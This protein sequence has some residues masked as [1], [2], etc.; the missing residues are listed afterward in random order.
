MSLC[1]DDNINNTLIGT[2]SRL[3]QCDPYKLGDH[4]YQ[5]YNREKILK[6][7]RA[8]KVR[9]SYKHQDT[10]HSFDGL[11]VFSTK[12]QFA[13][14]GLYG[15]TVQQHFYAR[16]GL[17]LSHI[18][19]PCAIIHGYS[20][21]KDFYPLE[22][23]SLVSFTEE[24]D[25]HRKVKERQEEE[26]ENELV[27]AMDSFSP[28]TAEQKF[29]SARWSYDVRSDTES[30]LM[31]QQ[32]QQQQQQ[33]NHQPTRERGHNPGVIGGGGEGG[34]RKV[35]DEFVANNNNAAG[36]KEV[37]S[38]YTPSLSCTLSGCGCATTLASP[39]IPSLLDLPFL[40]GV[41]ASWDS[42]LCKSHNN[43]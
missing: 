15:V 42:P 25:A 38:F 27:E 3:L 14:N 8:R 5:Q 6:F 16:H 41:N 36:N 31:K 39:P 12:K 32:Q 1:E 4:I 20:G 40:G 23:L 35:N 17:H 29:S 43:Y 7:M 21:R 19:L 33:Q 26:E 24:M 22:V 28:Y 11:S 2:F 18:H 37:R 30:R 9:F 10:I 13:Y 34:K